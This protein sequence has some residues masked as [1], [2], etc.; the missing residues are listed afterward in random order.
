MATKR[1]AKKRT[2]K[3]REPTL[4]E[5]LAKRRTKYTPQLAASL[6]EWLRQGYVMQQ[7][8]D[9]NDVCRTSITNWRNAYPDFGEEFARAKD[10]GHDAIAERARLTAATPELGVTHTVTDDEDGRSEKSVTADML[11]HRK[12]KIDTDLKL[13]A[14]WNPKKYGDRVDHKV[15]GKLD[16]ETMIIQAHKELEEERSGEAE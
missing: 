12:L 3:K 8:L 11:G 2:T 5:L 7:W 10:E 16:I 14:K 1:K 6:L 4:R 9:D 15:E 13:L